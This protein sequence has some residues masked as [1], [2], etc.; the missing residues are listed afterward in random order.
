M[1]VGEHYISGH[2]LRHFS[3]SQQGFTSASVSVPH[4]DGNP[5]DE[6]HEH[7]YGQEFQHA[8]L[9]IKA[10]EDLAYGRISLKAADL[11]IVPQ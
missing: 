6:R 10:P 8:E 2:T 9:L 5:D 4:L 11:G 7:D 3:D 1:D